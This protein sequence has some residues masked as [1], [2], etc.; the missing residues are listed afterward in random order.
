MIFKQNQDEFMPR[1][2]QRPSPP[3]F[4]RPYKIST[5][6]TGGIGVPTVMFKTR[7]GNIF[8]VGFLNLYVLYADFL[9][10]KCHAKITN[11]NV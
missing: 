10:N 6:L 9:V 11:V 5:L 1:G 7:N 2:G 3:V 8:T 4:H